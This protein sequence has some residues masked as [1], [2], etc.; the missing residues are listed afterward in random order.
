MRVEK[1]M[2]FSANSE[3]EC[4]EKADEMSYELLEYMYN[5]C[6][7]YKEDGHFPVTPEFST[8]VN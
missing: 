4:Q 8:L 6:I 3:T 7:F 1:L 2:F 5:T